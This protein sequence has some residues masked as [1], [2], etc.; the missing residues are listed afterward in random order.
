MEGA[1]FA[2]VPITTSEINTD[3]EVDLT[4]SHDVIQE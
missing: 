3:S 2:R 4:S 1:G